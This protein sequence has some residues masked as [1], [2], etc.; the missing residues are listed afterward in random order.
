MHSLGNFLNTNWSHYS[1]IR[2]QFRSD[3]LFYA[4][5]ENIIHFSMLFRCQN[6]TSQYLWTVSAKVQNG[7]NI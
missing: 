7:D 3:I 5:F 6:V 2:I 4:Q 1:Y